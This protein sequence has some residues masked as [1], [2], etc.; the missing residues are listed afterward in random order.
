METLRALEL[1]CLIR[2]DIHINKKIDR[3]I[4]LC[5][6]IRELANRRGPVYFHESRPIR[7]VLKE[8]WRECNGKRAP[9]G[10]WWDVVDYRSRLKFLE[11]LSWHLI[12]KLKNKEK[13]A[14]ILYMTLTDFY[15]Y[16]KIGICEI[17]FSF[18][19][20][21][22]ID[23]DDFMLCISYL[24]NHRP[25]SFEDSCL[26]WWP[27]Y[28]KEPRIKFLKKNIERLKGENSIL[29]KFWCIILTTLNKFLP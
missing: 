26:F 4:T 10:A 13:L 27:R 3:Y 22:F 24:K 23:H 9:A 7:E 17:L 5:I 21:G 2:Q 29:D 20:G 12:N 11:D 25:L 16:R 6:S 19:E 18:Q 28:E 8:Y 1:V 14:G 15:I